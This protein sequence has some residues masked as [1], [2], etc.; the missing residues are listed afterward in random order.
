MR[1]NKS[2]SYFLFVSIIVGI[3]AL[4]VLQHIRINGVIAR[5]MKRKQDLEMVQK[6]LER[7]YAE[8]SEYPSRV[9]LPQ[10]PIKQLS[11]SYRTSKD[12]QKY[13]LFARLENIRDADRILGLDADCG[14]PCTYGVTSAGTTLNETL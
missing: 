9:S 5:D 2:L 6:S 12:H 8:H 3:V 14:V 11:Y 1:K 7:Y 4:F 10:D 13:K